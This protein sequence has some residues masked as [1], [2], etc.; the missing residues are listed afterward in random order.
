[1]SYKLRAVAVAGAA[2]VALFFVFAPSP[3]LEFAHNLL[4][5]WSFALLAAS[6]ATLF[7]FLYWFFLRRII[8]ARHIAN[9]R[10]KRIMEER[11]QDQ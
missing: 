9:L 10:L 8:R 1:M 4:A 11:N 3:F 5:L 7:W 6:L 2:A